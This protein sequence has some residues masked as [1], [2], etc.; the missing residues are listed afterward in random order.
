M[1]ERRGQENGNGQNRED[2]QN[3]QAQPTSSTRNARRSQALPDIGAQMNRRS[4]LRLMIAPVVLATGALGWG[5]WNGG[6]NS[7]YSGPVSD[8]FDGVRFFNPGIEVD[9]SRADLLRFLVL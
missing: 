8:H 6:R 3:G 4:F 7:Y 2:L 5:R 9:K 1:T